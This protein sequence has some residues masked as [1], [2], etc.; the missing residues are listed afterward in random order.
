MLGLPALGRFELPVH[1][2]R[3]A[4]LVAAVAAAPVV[5]GG[6]VDDDPFDGLLRAASEVAAVLGCFAVFGRSLGLRR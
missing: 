1:P 2:W 6:A 5:L 4:L 3:F